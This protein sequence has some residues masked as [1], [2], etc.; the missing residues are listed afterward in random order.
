MCVWYDIEWRGDREE[1][2]EVFGVAGRGRG[3]GGGVEEKMREG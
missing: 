2:L 1:K 3:A